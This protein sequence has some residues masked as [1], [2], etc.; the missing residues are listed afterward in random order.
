M[1]Q[2]DYDN[3]TEEWACRLLEAVSLDEDSFAKVEALCFGTA[4][5]C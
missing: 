3:A 4:R 1:L 2:E 5:V